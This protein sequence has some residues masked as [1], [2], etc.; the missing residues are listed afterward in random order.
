M[1]K[2]LAI[3]CVTAMLISMVGCTP[4]AEEPK[5]G[6]QTP[7]TGEE[8]VIRIGVPGPYTGG[9][10][11]NGANVRY[12]VELAIEEINNAGGVNGIM[13][14]PVYADT[15]NKAEVAVSAYQKLCTTDEVDVI[16]GE[17]T[18]SIALAAMDIIAKYQIPTIFAIPSSDDLGRKISAEP[19][20]YGTIFMTDPPS[21]AMQDGILTFL[22]ESAANGV[23]KAPNKSIAF[24]SEDSDWG[25]SVS[26][27][28]RNK[29]TA[30][31]WTFVVD[32]VMASG[33]TDFSTVYTKVKKADPDIL[34]IEFT[35]V[36]SGVAAT[37]Q[38][39]EMGMNY[40]VFGGYYMKNAE[41]PKLAGALAQ[42][43]MNLKEPVDPEFEKKITARYS[44]A[45]A[46]A[47]CWSYD[48]IYILKEALERAGT[49]EAKALVEAIGE[50]DHA[51]VL[52]RTVYDPKTHFAISGPDYKFYGAAQL[53]DNVLY[54]VY[55]YDS[56][57]AKFQTPPNLD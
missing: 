45:S 33:E 36:T 14:E 2:T 16:V 39:Q 28:W 20:K 48:S 53:M 9:A 26:A 18:S 4:Q 21:S 41:F 11:T 34:K 42:Y 47:S 27:A 37:K 24:I 51:G 55:P 44:D 43:H 30:D 1:K 3:L 38:L 8:G 15:E 5:E 10:A 13:L 57:Q 23:I 35:N 19:E 17:V 46:V 25:K 31:G 54:T 29:L 22:E 56:A 50:T 32:E 7:A 52:M 40:V 6:S 12:G 49:K